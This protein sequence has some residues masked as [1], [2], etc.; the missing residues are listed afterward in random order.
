MLKRKSLIEIVEE[1]RTAPNK[2]FDIG[3]Y[4]SFLEYYRQTFA[5]LV[6]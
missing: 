5:E 3:G 4:F 6:K 1:E 2:R